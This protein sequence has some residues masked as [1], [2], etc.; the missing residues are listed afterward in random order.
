[1]AADPRLRADLAKRIGLSERRLYELAAKMKAEHGPM[2][3][4]DAMYVIAQMNGLDLTK[5]IADRDV[6][7]RIRVMVPRGSITRTPAK[8]PAP[9]TTA[10]TR[11]PVTRAI[12]VGST[13]AAAELLL[14]KAFEDDAERMSSLYPKMY[15]LENSIRNVIVR[16]LA[17][18]YGK[19]WWAL[20]A[21]TD[22]RNKVRDRKAKEAK[23]PWHGQRGSHE[24]YYSDFGDL[25][26]IIESKWSDF[27]P[28]L[29]SRP[30]ITQKLE[31][32]EPARNILAHHNPVPANEQKRLELYYDDWAAMIKDRGG[33]IPA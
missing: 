3:T 8:P 14:P 12:R 23:E 32:L 24:I 22:V 27:S 17:A 4:D 7:D 15:L 28:I 21:P 26:K 25:R 10:R 19:G 33:A 29:P 11:T 18:K 2:G 5:Y 31:E 9:A 6:V 20:C 16:V 13:A 1:V 30:W